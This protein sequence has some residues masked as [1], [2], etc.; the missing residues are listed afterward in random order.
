ME[1]AS[2]FVASPIGLLIEEVEQEAVRKHAAPHPRPASPDPRRNGRAPELRFETLTERNSVALAEGR[3][4]LTL[5][6]SIAVHAVGVAAIVV[7]PLLLSQGMP[8]P[9][10]G[11]RAFLVEPDVAAP[12]P[13]PPPPAPRS[14]AAAKVA[15]QAPAPDAG[16]FVAPV[17]VPTEIRPE[18]DLGLAGGIQ[19]G[20]PGGVEGG[21]PGGVVGGIVGGLPDTPPPAP[22]VK[23]IRVGGFVKE[24]K[25]TRYVAP[26]YPQ[27]A[28]QARLQG[29]V[30]IEATID[31]KGNVVDA[32]VL[33]GQPMLDQAALEAVRQWIYTPT[34]LDG[35]PTPVLMVVTVNF[36]LSQNVGA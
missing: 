31:A 25:R 23:P 11:V 21:V 29:V 10:G 20:V 27:L 12:P 22:A 5:P 9:A 32:K 3:R 28:V 17:E 2:H 16:K 15:P 30:I 18:S 19:G 8:E 14:S 13:P 36:R 24:P 6:V 4:R 26:E 34:F 1:P 35:H 7:I 33:R